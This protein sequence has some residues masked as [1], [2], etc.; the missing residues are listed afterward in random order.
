[1]TFEIEVTLAAGAAIAAALLCGHFLAAL[2]FP[3]PPNE[4]RFGYIDGVRGFLGMSVMIHHYRLWSLVFIDGAS[5]GTAPTPL[6]NFGAGA[7]AIFFTITGLV[8]YS[9]VLAGLSSVDWFSLYISRALRILPAVT[10]SVMV[11]TLIIYFRWGA[12]GSIWQNMRATLIWISAWD[13][14]AL[15]GH[16]ES[17]RLN[18]AVFWSLRVEWL[19][20]IILLPVMAFGRQLTRPFLPSWTIPLGLVV[21]S[22]FIQSFIP[23]LSYWP[24]F[25]LLFATGMLVYEIRER[26]GPNALSGPAL[27]VVALSAI[28]LSACAYN[29]PYEMPAMMGYAIFF[30]IIACGNSIFG[31][32]DTNAAKVLGEIS[33]SIYILHGIVLDVLFVNI[34]PITLENLSI[35]QLLMIIPVPAFAVVLISAISFL[36]IEK[37]GM[38]LGRKINYFRRRRSSMNPIAEKLPA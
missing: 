8:F 14:P 33:F 12:N 9:R 6:N 20:Y 3:L 23:T 4:G 19:F 24:R 25:G 30:L 22:L 31:I 36:L 28:F 10:F 16:A 17:A 21:V 15:L 35:M 13:Q 38:A 7:V 34:L 29:S 18:A 2:G 26:I 5:W 37:P 27:S 11:I 1:M 32:L